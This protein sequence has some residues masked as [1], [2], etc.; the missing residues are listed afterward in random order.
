M[1]LAARFVDMNK[2]ESNK[3]KNEKTEEKKVSDV[4]H[5][6]SIEQLT[7]AEH[8]CSMQI[9]YGNLNHKICYLLIAYECTYKS[10]GCGCGSGPGS[11]YDMCLL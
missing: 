10:I 11:G 6:S 9:A 5:I 7:Y 8:I 1:L 4:A 2:K 3:K